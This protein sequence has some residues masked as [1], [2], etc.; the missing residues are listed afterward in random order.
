MRTYKLEGKHNLTDRKIFDAF[1]KGLS[2]YDLKGKKIV[3]LIPDSTRSGPYHI[4]VRSIIRILKPI[5]NKI[6][7]LIALGTH[8]VMTQEQIK[9]FLRISKKDEQGLFKDVNIFNHLW[10]DKSTF[11]KIG[12]L[13]EK[14]IEELSAG[15]FK[16]KL[17]IEINKIIFNYDVIIV[18]CPVFPHEVVGFSGGVK[19]LFPGICG[20]EFLNF[21]HWFGAVLTNVKV[22]GVIDTPIRRLIERANEFIKIPQIFMG[23][24]IVNNKVQGIFI[25][26]II[27]AWKEAAGAASR[28]HIVYLK[29]K[30]SV[31]LGIAP[32]FYDDIWTAGKVMYKLEPVVAD[33]GE[34]IIY[35]PHINEISYTHGKAIRKIGYHTRDYFQK[36]ME[37]FG[38]I[39]RGVMAHS[40][41]VR[42]GGTFENNI[43]KPRIIVTLAAGIKEEVCRKINLNFRD[44]RQ[45]NIKDWE[46]RE[47]EGILVVHNAGE[48]LY[49]C[50]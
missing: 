12:E 37:K 40:T 11:I 27:K 14:E 48:T 28:T 21:F 25:G 32:K 44:H 3:V 7:F 23:L 15:L 10:N 4:L 29:K 50:K 24:D 42:G 5:V 8:P 33:G 35:A 1:E 19:Y 41:H 45:I 43:E 31:V 9:K 18:L 20:W 13:S 2:Q 34:L 39:P 17:S 22:N 16:E 26:D 46:N 47:K 6:D 30:Y 38:N 36:Q 49:R